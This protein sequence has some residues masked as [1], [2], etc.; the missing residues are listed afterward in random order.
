MVIYNT[1]FSVPEELKNEFLDFIRD[2]YIPLSTQSNIMKEPRLTRIFSKDEDDDSSY[3]LEF[4][5]DTIE[6]LEEWNKIIGRKLY[7]LTM[8]KFRQNI[9]GFATLLQ[10]IDL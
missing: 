1:T 8:K 10:P 7:F 6:A 3:A 9:Q 5:A 4:K 2:E